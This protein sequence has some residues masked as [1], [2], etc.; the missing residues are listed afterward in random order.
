[1]ALRNSQ[2][3]FALL[4]AVLISTIVL[5][6]GISILN[7]SLKEYVFSGIGRESEIAF[8]A[9]DAGMECALYWDASS[10]GGKFSIQADPPG[11]IVC[12]GSSQAATGGSSGVPQE[13]QFSWGTPNVC[14]KISVTKYFSSSGG[15]TM[16][17]GSTCPQNTT[18]TEVE[19]RGYNTD[20]SL[21]SDRVVE[22]ALRAVY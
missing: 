18:C 11:N 20:C 19:S 15:V 3:G 5:A 17:N 14:A 21:N 6:I 1:M 13:Y 2:S 16:S 9:A 7:L 12:V 22:R 4:L 10:Q 8:Y